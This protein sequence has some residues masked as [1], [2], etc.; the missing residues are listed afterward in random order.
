MSVTALVTVMTARLVQ[1]AAIGLI[2]P[3]QKKDS[4]TFL[5]VFGFNF[6]A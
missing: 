4:S 1:S 3:K 2:R 5:S 6:A